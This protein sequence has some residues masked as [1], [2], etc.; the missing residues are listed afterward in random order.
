MKKSE[1][2][3]MYNLIGGRVKFS[4]LSNEKVR[5]EMISLF[6]SLRKAISPIEDEL[7]ITE[8]PASQGNAEEMRRNILD[9]EYSGEEI[10]KISEDSLVTAFAESGVDLPI[11]AVLNT[12][13]PVLKN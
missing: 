10:I 13:N 6:R 4:A 2:F 8:T 1:V 7:K 9:E 11:L 5:K 3:I 12:F